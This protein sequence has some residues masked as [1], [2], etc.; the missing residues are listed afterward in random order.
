MAKLF[1]GRG[2][3]VAPHGVGSRRDGPATRRRRGRRG[4]QRPGRRPGAGP[5]RPGG[6]GLR[7]GRRRR[8]WLS[9]GG[10]RRAGVPPRRLRHRA[11]P[12]RRIPVL[13]GP[14]PRP[15]RGRPGH[16]RRLLRPPARRGPGR[17]GPPVR[18]RDRGLAR[19]RRAG[20][21]AAAGP[22]RPRGRPRR[23]RHPR[24]LRRPPRHPV[25][26]ARF[27]MRGLLPATWLAS[28]FETDGA[29]AL[30]A[31]VGAHS[32][33]PLGSPLTGAFALLLTALAHSAGWPVVEGGSARLVRALLDAL[34]GS[35]GRVRTG[36]WIRSLDDLPSGRA[37]VLDVTPRQL[38][39]L[40]GGRLGARE[41]RALARSRY[42]PGT[43]KVD[44]ALAGP[45]PWEADVC[46]DAATVH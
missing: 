22:A 25:A 4:A 45:V 19:A 24:P 30:L 11:P 17:R 33:L 10:A 14:G 16:P 34:A 2:I 6:G 13:R 27:G 20:L 36:R 18:R 40:A 3:T 28:R 39:G 42:G 32:M 35:G 9:Q 29:R 21:P 31:G 5:V 41:R 15:A 26:M 7:R 43:C 38:L 46:S 44:W 23:A 37:T 8:G 12:G 1:H